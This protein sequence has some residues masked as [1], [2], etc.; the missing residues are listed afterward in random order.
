VKTVRKCWWREQDLTKAEQALLDAVISAHH[1]SSMRPNCSSVGF[2]AAATG[3]GRFENAVAA[4]ILTTGGAHAPLL[5]TCR[6]LELPDDVL[7]EQIEV[8]VLN[9]ELVPGWGN[10][11]H[12]GVPDPIWVPV[13]EILQQSFPAMAKKLDVGTRALHRMGKDVY[14]NPSAYTAAAA[15]VL[16]IPPETAGWIFI[17]GRL[18][19]WAQAFVAKQQNV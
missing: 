8:A 15:L 11:F 14:P 3:A 19:A 13:H 9:G 7:T 6:A 1:N 12:K 16:G 17:V 18:G 2:E 4:A 10:S 5:Q